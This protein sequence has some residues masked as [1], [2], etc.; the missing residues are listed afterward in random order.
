MT[1]FTIVDLKRIMRDCAGVDES[2]DLDGDIGDAEF[3]GLGYDSLALLEIQ[4]RVQQE[5][6]VAMP[7]EALEH[8]TTPNGAVAYV[9]RRMKAAV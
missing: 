8:M 2:I 3:A 6:G 7:D 9:N 4:A 5:F 1:E